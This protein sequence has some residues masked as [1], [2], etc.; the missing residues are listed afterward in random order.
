MPP[1][2]RSRT[3]R[4]ERLSAAEARRIALAAQGFAD[5]AARR[6]AVGLGRPAPVRPRRRCCR[7]TRS[8]CS[9]APTTC[10]CSAGS[11][12]TTPTLLD[13]AAHY[14]PRRLFEYWGHEASLLPVAPA[15]AAALAHGARRRRGLGRHAARSSASGPSWWREVLDEVRARGPVAASEVLAH[16]RAGAHRA[17]GGTGATSSARSSGCSGAASSPRRGGAAFERLY[18]LPERVLPARGPAHADA[19]RR[20]R[21]ARARARS[22]R[23][24]LGVAAERD[25]R[26]YFRL[27]AA[28]ARGA[29]RRARRGGRAARRSRSRAGARPPTSTRARACRG[30]VDAQ[31]PRRPVRLADLGARARRSG[32]SASATG[33]RS[34]SPRPSACTATTCS[35]SCSA[36]GS[37]RASTS[38][39]TGRPARCCVQAAHA[40]PDAPPRDR[41]RA[42]RRARV[43]GRLAGARARA[44]RAARRP[45]GAAGGDATLGACTRHPARPSRSSAPAAARWPSRSSAAARGAAGLP[46]AALAGAARGRTRPDRRDARRSGGAVR[47]RRRRAR[48]AAR[49]RGER[50]GARPRRLLRGRHATTSAR[51]STGGCRPRHDRRPRRTAGWPASA[52]RSSPR[53]PRWPRAPA[54]STS[55]RASRTPTGRAEV[56]EAAVAA[57]RA[58]HNQYPP[59]TGHPAR[60][61]PAIA[62]HQRRF[63]GTELDPDGE[64]LVTD[65][66]HRGDRRRAAR[67]VRAGRR[68]RHLRA[69]LRLLR[70]LHRAG[71]RR[72][73]RRSRCA[74]PTTRSTP[75]RS[76]PRSRRARGSCCSTRRTTRPAR[77]STRAELELI[78][79]PCRERDVLAVTDEVYE[80]LVF[81]GAPHVPLPTLPGMAERTLTISSA[82]KTFSF[83][84]WKIGWAVRPAGAGRARCRP[85]SS[86][87]R[88]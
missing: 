50:R 71:R 33:S 61:G 81:D 25:L 36:T 77:C 8:T 41:G 34:T 76:P 54:R 84:G 82:G 62:A 58:G 88:S 73:A 70:R 39:P 12:R 21:P 43:D 35:R 5:P 22:P 30:A 15:A 40:E 45:R 87:S 67:A 46:A 53:C 80:H 24:S 7:S 16:E 9:S 86:S 47:R 74:R 49:P 68:G 66:R 32:C 4:K 51:S 28:D 52:R 11:A 13:R 72:A 64:V 20:G 2:R 65:G 27:P 23:A 38:R 42:A 63:Y 26:D 69:L 83:T 1:A 10:R 6:A 19:A 14:A 37:S 17:R 75:T 55:A 29:R 79:G 31:R 59:G 18:D 78:A 85:P 48:P 3:R 60:C 56:L 44:R 57:I